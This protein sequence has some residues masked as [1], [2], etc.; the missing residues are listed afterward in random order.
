MV[1]RGS[2]PFGAR[3]RPGVAQAGRKRGSLKDAAVFG[4]VYPDIEPTKPNYQVIG[5]AIF[6]C[7]ANNAALL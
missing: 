3:R 6:Y 5:G 1:Q 7:D 4:V 2:R